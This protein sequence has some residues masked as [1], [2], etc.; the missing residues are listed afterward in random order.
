MS[1]E[2]KIHTDQG[3]SPCCDAKLAMG[4]VRG[5]FEGYGEVGCFI[6]FCA[7]CKQ[8]FPGAFHAEVL[9]NQI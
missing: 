6:L 7:K 5:A 4:H 1:D 8:I 2:T 3:H 9:K